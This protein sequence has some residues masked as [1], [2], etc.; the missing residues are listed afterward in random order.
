MRRERISG[1]KARSR[2]RPDLADTPR[3]DT[4][5]SERGRRLAREL[6]DR[7]ARIDDLLHETE[8]EV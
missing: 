4:T 2:R 5:T 6:A 8:K 1:P 3:A 7:I